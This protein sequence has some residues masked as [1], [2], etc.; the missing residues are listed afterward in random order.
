MVTLLNPNEDCDRLQPASGRLG[1]TL[2]ESAQPRAERAPLTAR[3][4]KWPI[5]SPLE[6]H[7]PGRCVKGLV[8]SQ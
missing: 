4:T 2:A 6:E 8:V 7:F 1:H 5:L 3:G